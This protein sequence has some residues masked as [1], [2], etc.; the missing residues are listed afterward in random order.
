M[1]SLPTYDPNAYGNATTN[2]MLNR[3]I[4]VIYEPGSVM[5][6]AVI[7]AAL[8]EGVVTPNTIIDCEQGAW[9][10]PGARAQGHAR[11]RPCSPWRTS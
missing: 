11:L 10:V 3:A 8:N 5:K 7:A 6:A 9:G 1:V 2:E 4:G